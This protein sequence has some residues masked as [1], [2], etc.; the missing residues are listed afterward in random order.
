M[1]GLGKN[2]EILFDMQILDS[3]VPLRIEIG[4]EINFSPI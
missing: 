1:I 2:S 3:D 4:F